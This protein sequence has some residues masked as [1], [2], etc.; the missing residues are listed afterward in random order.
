M[1]SERRHELQT[2]QLADW[3]ADSAEKIKPYSNTI[4]GV[5]VIL[6]AVF[7]GYF[8]WAQKSAAQEAQGWDRFFA[9]QQPRDLED[10]IAE[11]PD[12]P[13]A[14]W[15]HT[16]IG[17]MQTTMGCDRLFLNKAAAMDDL[18]DGAEHFRKALAGSRHPMILQRATFGLA[19][20]V[21][22]QAK[23]LDEAVKCYKEVVEK[24]PDGTYAVMA[25][26]RLEDLSQ[27]STR[28]WY[29]DYFVQFNPTPPS[30]D[31]SGLPGDP[32]DHT[33]GNIPEGPV[34]GPESPNSGQPGA[35]TPSLEDLL[36]SLD[37]LDSGTAET[38]VAEPN[39]T[40]PDATEPD[41]ADSDA[42][43]PETSESGDSE[44]PP[45]ET[46]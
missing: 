8:W 31:P 37:T 23:D 33:F 11:F 20:N 35:G 1:K 12:T 45:T 29:D 25:N 16:T 2:N 22:A 13:V 3:L 14:Y 15:A 17:D 34:L 32:L 26:L 40:E 7:G 19:R 6:V 42:T 21:E 5:A 27:S 46:E 36:K 24:W 39:A 18:R 44:E 43:A 38:D 30:A 28:K 4:L 9:A 41:A 10:V